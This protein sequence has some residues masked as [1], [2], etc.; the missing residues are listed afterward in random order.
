LKITVRKRAE[1]DIDDIYRY[2]ADRWGIVQAD[3]YVANLLATFSEIALGRLRDMPAGVP[4]ADLR[5][6]QY[7]A[8]YIFFQKLPR[9]LVIVR[10][11]H[12]RMDM[13]R[14]LR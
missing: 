6:I 2:S 8:H 9:E 5:R 12:H 1:A 10:V 14:H 4:P 3:R 11:L 7:H 13:T